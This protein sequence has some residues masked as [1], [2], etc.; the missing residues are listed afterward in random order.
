MPVVRPVKMEALG[1]PSFP[2][3]IAQAIRELLDFDH[4]TASGLVMP[5]GL[6]E[7][8]FAEVRLGRCGRKV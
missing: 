6:G 7:Q 2:V 5:C 8:Q 3:S 1:S 4:R